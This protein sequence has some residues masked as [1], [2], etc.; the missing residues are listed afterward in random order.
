MAALC[1]NRGI[2]CNAMEYEA[3]LEVLTVKNINRLCVY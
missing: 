2:H 1:W 3:K